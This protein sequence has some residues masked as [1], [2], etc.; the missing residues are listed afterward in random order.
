MSRP[1][2]AWA[3]YD[4][5]ERY[6]TA[7]NLAAVCQI[8]LREQLYTRVLIAQ[9][10]FEEIVTSRP[11]NPGAAEIQSAGWLEIKVVTN[12]S[13]VTALELE[14]DKGEAESLALAVELGADLV[15]VDER[16]GRKVASRLG[17]NRTG[18]LGV[19][20]VAKKRGLIGNIRPILDDLK[21]KAGFWISDDVYNETLRLAG[22]AGS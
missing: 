3:S 6:F 1:C 5:S 9:A 21:N 16:K 7:A 19:L 22:E 15:L 20:L 11:G 12:R 13:I 10:V 2:V 8:N 18:I 4:C 14:L 17:L